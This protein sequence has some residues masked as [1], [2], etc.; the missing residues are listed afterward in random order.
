MQIKKLWWHIVAMR[1]P[2]YAKTIL[3]PAIKPY[4]YPLAQKLNNGVFAVEMHNPNLGFFAQLNWCL[5]VLFYCERHGLTP[6]IE[7]TASNYLSPDHGND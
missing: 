6:Y 3:E 1:D 2:H 4:Y 5:F 7:L